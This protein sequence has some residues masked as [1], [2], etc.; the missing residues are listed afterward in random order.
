MCKENLSIGRAIKCTEQ[1]A[2]MNH[3]LS[4]CILIPTLA[5]YTVKL[6]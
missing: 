5:G 6:K 1:A 2:E 4:A 3:E